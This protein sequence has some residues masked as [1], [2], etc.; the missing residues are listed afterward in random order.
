MKLDLPPHLAELNPH[1][2]TGK[3]RAQKVQVG[4]GYRSVLERRVATE[5]IP[6]QN[7]TAWWYEPVTFSLPGGRYTPDFFLRWVHTRRGSGLAFVEVKGWTQ[8]LRADRRAFMEAARTHTWADWLWLTWDKKSGWV[9]S[10][11]HEAPA[12]LA[13][14]AGRCHPVSVAR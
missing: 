6:A 12:G 11:G 8:S 3:G 7:V 5:W 2:V 14:S 13:A 9:E 4:D 1:L 10:S